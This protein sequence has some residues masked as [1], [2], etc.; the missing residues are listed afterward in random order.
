MWWENG[1]CKDE[2]PHGW[3]LSREHSKKQNI[4][5]Q[6]WFGNSWNG[7]AKLKNY[8]G[9]KNRKRKLEKEEDLSVACFG[10]LV[11][12]CNLCKETFEQKYNQVCFNVV[13]IL[14]FCIESLTYGNLLHF[15]MFIDFL[16]SFHHYICCIRIMMIVMVGGFWLVLWEMVVDWSM[17]IVVG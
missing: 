10:K 2:R 15:M 7:S 4:K 3:S 12:E 1:V 6:G 8:D 11:Q 14:L 5:E 16:K 13:I 9:M 17:L